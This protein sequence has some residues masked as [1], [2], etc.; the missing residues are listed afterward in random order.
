MNGNKVWNGA[1]FHLQYEYEIKDNA[2]LIFMAE[3]KY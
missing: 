2:M 3:K 1:D